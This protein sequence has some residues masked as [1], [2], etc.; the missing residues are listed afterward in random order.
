LQCSNAELEAGAGRTLDGAGVH[1]PGG[2]FVF[3]SPT[4]KSNSLATLEIRRVG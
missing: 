2:Y 3:K 4:N 1:V